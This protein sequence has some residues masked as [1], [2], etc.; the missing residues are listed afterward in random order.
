MIYGIIPARLESTR[1]PRKMLL[2]ETGKPLIQHTWEAV[3]RAMCLDRVVVA[4]DSEEI[5]AWCDYFGAETIRTGPASSGTDRCAEAARQLQN[6]SIIINIQ[7]DEPEIDQGHIGT[8]VSL[9]ESDPSAHMATLATPLHLDEV[10]NRSC[11]K[12]LCGRDGDAVHF[13]RDPI[14]YAQRHIGVYAY[15]PASLQRFVHIPVST[16][17]LSENLEQVRCLM[18]GWR[19]R[20][21]IVASAS[22]GID[23]PEDYR[24][25][26][27]RVRNG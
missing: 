15:R 2:A 23:T 1:L 10:T 25:F 26:V 12:V 21:G 14:P 4:T 20:V 3:K 11:V 6:A 16:M 27:E 22:H 5:A 24:R 18:D 19:I 9:I 13:T 17:E 8:L 7:G